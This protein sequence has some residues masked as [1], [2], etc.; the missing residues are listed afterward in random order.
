[1]QHREEGA[2]A[3]PKARET[4]RSW[5]QPS[6]KPLL[7]YMCVCI[8]HTHQLQHHGNDTNKKNKKRED[9]DDEAFIVLVMKKKEHLETHA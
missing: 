1:V 6:A 3:A 2:S 4:R 8:A 5:H 9:Q 7:A